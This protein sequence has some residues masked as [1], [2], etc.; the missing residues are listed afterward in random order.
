VEHVLVARTC[1]N[2][3]KNKEL[4]ETG[5]G[6]GSPRAVGVKMIVL[7]HLV[8]PDDPTVT[9]RM[10]LDAAR[11]HFGGEVIVGRDLLEV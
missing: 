3:R 9:D 8:P 1:T 11:T 4:F 10:W 2:P 6:V 5:S 7:S